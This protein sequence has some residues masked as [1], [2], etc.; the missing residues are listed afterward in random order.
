MANKARQRRPFGGA[1]TSCARLANLASL[2]LLAIPALAFPRPALA[3]YPDAYIVPRGVLRVSFEPSYTSWRERY[4]STGNVEGLGADFTDSTAGARLFPTMYGAQA[5]IR[6]I[7]AD[8]A[9]AVNL[10]NFRL[11]RDADVRR[12]PFHFQFGLTN[13]LTLTAS[14]P[15]VTTRSQVTFTTD[16]TDANVGWN[17][18]AAE[19]G[20]ASAGA[21]F[22][23]LLTQLEAGASYVESQIAAGAYGCPTDPM[24]DEASATVNRARAFAGNIAAMSGIDAT[25]TLVD[26]LPPFAP[27]QGSAA[28]TAI[29]AEAVSIST[30]LASFGAPALTA[31]VPLPTTRIGV[32]GVNA[33]LTDSAFGYL[34]QPLEFS[35]YRNTLGDIEVGFRTGLLQAGPVRAVLVTTARLPTGKRDLPDHLLDIGSGDRQTDFIF[36]L[37]TV[38]QPSRFF[39]LAMSGSYTLQLPDRLQRRVTPHTVPIV[40]LTAQSAVDRNLGDEL[41]LVAYPSLRL[42][43]AFTAYFSASYWKKGADSYESCTPYAPTELPLPAGSTCGLDF[44]S[45]M[46]TL[47]LGAGIHYRA[48]RG[49]RG[50]SLPV[51]AGIDYH[52]AFR[53]EGGQTPK[54]AGVYFYLRLYYRLFGGNEPAGTPEGPDNPLVPNP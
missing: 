13:W 35:K 5:A 20:N 3:Q 49:R 6:G 40:P 33:V 41:R 1:R 31:T 10:G 53:G 52:A 27:L 30:A 50:V 25:G 12:T 14:I 38:L 28:G 29:S 2:T 47:Y 32:E 11:L 9:Y 17:Q 36:G 23:S 8:D 22:Q 51:E 24:C 7:V 37:E 54:D 16:S 21:S 26:E 34:L 19:A 15:F 4:D 39:A 48:V 45:A 46:R 42:S 43:D 44:E 18:L